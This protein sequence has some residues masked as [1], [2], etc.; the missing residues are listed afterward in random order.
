MRIK[1][2]LLT[3]LAIAYMPKVLATN[4]NLSTP[5]SS[6][7][8]SYT[9]T[10]SNPYG[11]YYRLQESRNGAPWVDIIYSTSQTAYTFNKAVGGTYDYRIEHAVPCYRYCYNGNYSYYYSDI[12]TIQ[13]NLTS[14]VLPTYP[15]N[16]QGPSSD[17]DGVFP[18]TWVS[19]APIVDSYDVQEQINGGVWTNVGTV[20]KQLIW[21]TGRTNGSYKY[22][23]RACN[24]N[25]CG[26]Y[27]FYFYG[28]VS[29]NIN[30]NAPVTIGYSYDELGR[31]KSVSDSKS[32]SSQFIYDDAGNRLDVTTNNDKG[33]DN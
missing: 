14:G 4:Y 16:V 33:N 12:E 31:L 29:V 25:G 22:R 26:S 32:G 7:N 2:T 18:I 9:V 27:S 24:T 20:S 13:V 8:G 11:S 23:V 5:A 6:S 10:W 3:L 21:L 30:A 28:S 1:L 19:S 17:N 15:N